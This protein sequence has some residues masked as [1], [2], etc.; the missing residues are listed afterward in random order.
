MKGGQQSI[1]WI[2]LED[3]SV[4]ARSHG[5]TTRLGPGTQGDDSKVIADLSQGWYQVALHQASQPPMYQYHVGPCRPGLCQ[6]IFCV[7]GFTHDVQPRLLP[8]QHPQGK[9]YFRLFV[10]DQDAHVHGSLPDLGFCGA[11]IQ[12]KLSKCIGHLESF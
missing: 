7:D 1:G 4:G 8:Q 5:G 2:D 6:E 11:S 10:G 9:S 3:K 12:E